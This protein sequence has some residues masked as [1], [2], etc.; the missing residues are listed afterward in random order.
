MMPIGMVAHTNALRS[1]P[2]RPAPSCARDDAD[3]DQARSHGDPLDEIREPVAS[4]QDVHRCSIAYSAHG[5][6]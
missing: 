2:A 5:G 6:W 1:W 4:G 3:A